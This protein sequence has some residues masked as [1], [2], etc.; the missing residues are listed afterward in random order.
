MITRYF[1]QN[2]RRLR[3][4]VVNCW[5]LLEWSIRRKRDSDQDVAFC[6]R[7]VTASAKKQKTKSET[8]TEAELVGRD[9]GGDTEAMASVVSEVGPDLEPVNRALDEEEAVVAIGRADENVDTHVVDTACDCH[10]RD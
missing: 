10:S 5:R 7:F 4:H 3:F 2:D 8:R 6:S 1:P 9:D